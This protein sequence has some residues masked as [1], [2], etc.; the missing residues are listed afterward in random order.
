M[1]T[2]T[3]QSSQDDVYMYTPPTLPAHLA[4]IYDL[5]PITGQPTNEQVITIHAAMRAVNAEAQIPHLCNPELSL[6]LSQHL[7]SVQMAIYRNAYPLSILP[8]DNTYAPPSLPTHIPI[9]LETVTGSPSNEQLKTAQD[10]MRIVES[11]GYGPLF[12]P[13]LNMHL[14]QHLFNLQ[15]ARYIQDS[16]LGQFTS[17][18]NASRHI[19]LNNPGSDEGSDAGSMAGS[20]A[21]SGGSSDA[22]SMAG[23]LEMLRPDT[24]DTRPEA[25]ITQPEL[26]RSAVPVPNITQPL[27]PEPTMDSHHTSSE[28]SQLGQSMNIIK[29][30]M[31]ESKGVLENINRVLIATQRNQT[32]VGDYSTN[33]Y[34]HCNPVNDRGVTAVES[35]LPQLRYFYYN[36]NYYINGYL[37]PAQLAGYL[38]F[39][40]IGVDLIEGTDNDV[41]RLKDGVQTQAESLIMKHLGLVY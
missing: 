33:I 35:G 20:N 12:D 15:L 29:E 28:I 39:F 41:P 16:T 25:H 19:P 2:E 9:T 7:F 30:L 32:V 4:T 13:D 40:D 34:V 17:R 36:R 22:G 14:S 27:G 11:R 3:S 23:S 5:K 31:S 24:I 8:R 18:P 21:G 10:A 26:T 1:I 6:Q 37:N 38:R